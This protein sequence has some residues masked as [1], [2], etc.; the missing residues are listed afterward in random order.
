MSE[1]MIGVL[2]LF[3]LGMTVMGGVQLMLWLDARR[4]PPRKRD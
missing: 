1:T 3:A 4:N 2:I